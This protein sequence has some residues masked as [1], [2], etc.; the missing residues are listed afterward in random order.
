M[1]G[2]SSFAKPLRQKP[3]RLALSCALALLVAVGFYELWTWPQRPG[4]NL[5]TVVEVPS[6]ASLA[7]VVAVLEEQGLVDHPRLFRVYAQASGYERRLR[8]GIYEVAGNLSPKALLQLLAS[9]K[10]QQHP[11][12]IPEGATLAQLLPRLK[13]QS[14]LTHEVKD[15]ADL[16]RQL[17]LALPFLEGVFFPETYYVARGASDLSVLQRAHDVMVTKLMT[18]WERRDPTLQLQSPAE[19][20]VLASIIEKE[21]DALSDRR[22]ISQVFHLRLQKNMRLQTDPT[23]IYALGQAFDG[24]LRRR[25]LRVDSPFNTYRYPGLP[26]APIALPSAASIEAA[27]HPA[28]GD[29]LYFVARGDGTSQFS[30]TLAEHNAAVRRYQL[31]GKRQSTG[32]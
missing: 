22:Q 27:L 16:Y 26:P 25:D 21:S 28:P 11:I 24:D 17:N 29:Y 31:S 12:R 9:G 4:S 5:A 19:A 8:A 6:G 20:L 32:P 1:A 3:V 30:R 18:A 7:A 10:V 14:V 23:V 2:S 15:A 13:D